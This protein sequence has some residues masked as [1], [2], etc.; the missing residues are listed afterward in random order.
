MEAINAARTH[1][2]RA[3]AHGFQPLGSHMVPDKAL[4]GVEVQQPSASR[5]GPDHNRSIESATHNRS[6][7]SITHN[8]CVHA[9][10]DREWCPRETYYSASMGGNVREW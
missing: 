9:R 3:A 10:N 7:K 5:N 2:R 8:R 6:L 4:V 1:N